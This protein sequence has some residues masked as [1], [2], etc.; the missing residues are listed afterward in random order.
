MFVLVHVCAFI[1]GTLL[2]FI[3][4]KQLSLLSLY[5]V[6]NRLYTIVYNSCRQ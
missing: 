5:A 4:C 3:N 6:Y 2:G 1:K